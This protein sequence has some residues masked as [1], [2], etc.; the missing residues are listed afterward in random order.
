MNCVIHLIW[1]Q[2]SERWLGMSD[3]IPGLNLESHSIELLMD[4]M[5]RE[6]PFFLETNR[7]YRGPIQLDFKMV[8]VEQLEA[9]S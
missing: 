6:A 1:E 3:D 2:E 4:W 8:R 5:K 9:A 7:D